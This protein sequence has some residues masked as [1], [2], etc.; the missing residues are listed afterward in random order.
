MHRKSI[1]TYGHFLKYPVCLH[2]AVANQSRRVFLASVGFKV[3]AVDVR[4]SF[5]LKASTDSAPAALFPPTAGVTVLTRLT[6]DLSS[7]TQVSDL[8]K[9]NAALMSYNIV[10]VRPDSEALFE[11]AVKSGLVDIVHLNCGNKLPFL[12]RKTH[13]RV[14]LF[15]YECAVVSA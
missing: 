4:K 3:L 1:R 6:A 11:A 2:D 7:Y 12:L 10:A 15:L 9:A 13:V 5:P 8:T 14:C